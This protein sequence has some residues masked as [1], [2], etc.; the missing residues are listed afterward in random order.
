MPSTIYLRT[1]DLVGQTALGHHFLQISKMAA[2][3]K[4]LHLGIPRPLNQVPFDT[5]HSGELIATSYRSCRHTHSSSMC[6]W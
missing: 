1:M 4:P 6:V 3:H 5:R 2:T